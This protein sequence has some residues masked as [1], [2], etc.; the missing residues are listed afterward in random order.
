MKNNFFKITDI[1]SNYCFFENPIHHYFIFALY[2]LFARN[3]LAPH[4]RHL[5]V[6]PF[7]FHKTFAGITSFCANKKLPWAVSGAIRRVLK[8]RVPSYFDEIVNLRADLSIVWN[9]IIGSVLD[10]SLIRKVRLLLLFVCIFLSISFNLKY[11]KRQ[12]N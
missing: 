7:Q 12:R 1:W 9:P 10:K 11:P 5:L 8:V 6:T 4:C 3:F 2:V